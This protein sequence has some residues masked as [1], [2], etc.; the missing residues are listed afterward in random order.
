MPERKASIQSNSES[1]DSLAD[2]RISYG[3][4]DFLAPLNDTSD[5]DLMLV[6]DTS[7]LRIDSAVNAIYSD[8]Y[9]IHNLI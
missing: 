6:V 9:L 4:P 3:H 7:A 8:M 2:S 5:S 1:E